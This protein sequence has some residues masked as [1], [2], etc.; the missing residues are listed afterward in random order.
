M[1]LPQSVVSR[2]F[3]YFTFPTDIASLYYNSIPF[4]S[5]VGLQVIV[6][7]HILTNVYNFFN[8]SSVCLYMLISHL[9]MSY[10]QVYFFILFLYFIVN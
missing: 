9:I 5:G 1:K 8:A 7:G 4:S 3:F 6:T 10:V 2:V